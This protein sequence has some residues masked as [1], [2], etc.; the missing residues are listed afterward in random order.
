MNVN[1]IAKVREKLRQELLREPTKSEIADELDDPSLIDDIEH[2]HTIIRLD[3][4]RTETGEA[5]LHEVLERNDEQSFED[6][7][8]NFEDD[9]MLILHKFPPREKKILCMYYGIGYKRTYN[10]REIG[11]ELDLTRERIRQIKEGTIDKLKKRPEGKLLLD[12]L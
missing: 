7:F 11:A 6:K 2:L 9:L 12:Y 5:T 8:E 3:V 10:L 4:P 1:K